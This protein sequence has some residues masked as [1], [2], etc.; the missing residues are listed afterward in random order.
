MLTMLTHLVVLLDSSSVVWDDLEWASSA[1][2]ASLTATPTTLASFDAFQ[3]LT[4]FAVA[5]IA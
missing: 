5:R 3:N 2:A 4:H 1:P